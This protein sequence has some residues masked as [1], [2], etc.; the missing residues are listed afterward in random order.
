MKR[1]PNPR[2]TPSDVI[3]AERELSPSL[4]ALHTRAGHDV[5]S[6]LFPFRPRTD[7]VVRDGDRLR[8]ERVRVAAVEH[9]RH[10]RARE[11][12]RFF[13]LD[14]IDGGFFNDK[15]GNRHSRDSLRC[16]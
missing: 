15:E 3:A 7:H 10:F 9:H 6:R 13:Q 1:G 12:A 5:A 8:R 11:P 16:F 4:C 14:T 2:K